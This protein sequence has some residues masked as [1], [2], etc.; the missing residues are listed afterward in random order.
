[1]GWRAEQIKVERDVV[2]G[3]RKMDLVMRETGAFG[4]R[5]IMGVTVSL[6]VVLFVNFS[7]WVRAV[8]AM[9]RLNPEGTLRA[10]E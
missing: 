1:M 2:F 7:R 6:C 9:V 10:W 5:W 8:L 4:A 3:A